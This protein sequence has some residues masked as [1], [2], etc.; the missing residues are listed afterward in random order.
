MIAALSAACSQKAPPMTE[1]Q[2]IGKWSCDPSKRRVS[3]GED[4][5]LSTIEYR[6]DHSYQGVVTSSFSAGN[7][8]VGYL[9][10]RLHEEGNW[11]I[12]GDELESTILV[13]E[14]LSTSSPRYGRKEV[15]AIQATLPHSDGVHREWIRAFDGKQRT[16]D[17]TAFLGAWIGEPWVCTRL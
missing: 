4:E 2:L 7:G 12:E 6:A 13:S 3:G 17:D 15:Q 10:M 5:T 9:S 1:A 11:R 8:V 16:M 14:V